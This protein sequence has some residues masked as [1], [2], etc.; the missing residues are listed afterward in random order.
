MSG[1]QKKEVV[2]AKK[3]QGKSSAGKGKK[4]GIVK[5]ILGFLIFQLVDKRMKKDL[6]AQKRI[7]K[8]DKGKKKPSSRKKRK[9]DF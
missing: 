6:R 3:F 7:E 8:R 4:V 2:V 9:V 1:R 5:E